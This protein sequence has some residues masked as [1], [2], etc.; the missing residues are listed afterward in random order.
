LTQHGNPGQHVG[1]N[2]VQY[3]VR[4]S[5]LSIKPSAGPP[6]FDPKPTP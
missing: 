5:I 4:G 3:T 1:T 6:P 2:T